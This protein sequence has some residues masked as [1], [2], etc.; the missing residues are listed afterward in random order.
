M[1]YKNVVNSLAKI[2]EFDD[3][4]IKKI[5][6]AIMTN[7]EILIDDFKTGSISDK[8]MTLLEIMSMTLK[9]FEN[10]DVVEC[11]VS[12]LNNE[13]IEIMWKNINIYAYDIE[14]FF[15]TRCE[16]HLKNNQE[17][18]YKIYFSIEDENIFIYVKDS[19]DNTFAGGTILIQDGKFVPVGAI[20]D[21]FYTP[22]MQQHKDENL[23]HDREFIAN[24]TILNSLLYI[25]LINQ[26]VNQNREVI[27]ETS[28]RIDNK[29]K[30]SSKKPHKKTTQV[31]YI[32]VDPIKVKKVR[33][34]YEKQTRESYN[35][36]IAEWSRRGHWTTLRN[37]KKHWIKPTTCHAKDKVEVKVQ[38]KIYK[39]K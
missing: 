4:Q 15:L 30:K 23:P 28:R 18:I 39:L 31:R 36:H 34:D 22:L 14:T 12:L 5:E 6:K 37:G 32:R 38:Q 21:A 2:L 33:D 8:Q 17:L 7:K 19:N 16:F 24:R 10:C 27:T 13:M 26:M 11:D 1:I 35:R 9:S 3:K 25:L 29:K 20:A